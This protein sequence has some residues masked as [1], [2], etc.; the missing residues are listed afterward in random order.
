MRPKK[1]M[2]KNES[3]ERK[4]GELQNNRENWFNNYKSLSERIKMEKQKKRKKN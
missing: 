1:N 3:D 4:K 2:S